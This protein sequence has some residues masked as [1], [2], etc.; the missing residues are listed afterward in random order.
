M[1]LW[2]YFIFLCT[3]WYIAN[4]CLYKRAIISIDSNRSLFMFNFFQNIWLQ[5]KMQFYNS[6]FLHRNYSSCQLSIFIHLLY[7]CFELIQ[8]CI[9]S[10]ILNNANDAKDFFL[11]DV[12]LKSIG[13]V[14][15][16]GTWYVKRCTGITRR[17]Q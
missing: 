15:V 10:C 1:W 12:F 9:V 8:L 11:N 16:L 17:S 2:H 3:V 13:S 4:Q 5:N 6:P 14:H 7:H